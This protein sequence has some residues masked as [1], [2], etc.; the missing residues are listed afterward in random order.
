MFSINTRKI[1]TM[2]LAGVLAAGVASAALA[3]TQWDKDHPR[4]DEVNDRLQNQ[5]KRIHHEVKEGEMSKAKAA[6]LHREDRAVRKEERRMAARHDGHITKAEQAKLN[7]Q[8]NAVS[9]QIGQ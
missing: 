2:A 1:V 7:R 3:E 4:R 9:K 5:D 6:K 8:E